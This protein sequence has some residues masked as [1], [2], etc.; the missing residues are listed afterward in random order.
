MSAVSIRLTPS[1]RARRSTRGAWSG[2]STIRIAPKPSRRT[3]SSPPSRNVELTPRSL[4][5]IL[6]QPPRHVQRSLRGCEPTGR[7]RDP[8]VDRPE[9]QRRP[10]LAVRVEDR[11]RNDP[12]LA[13][14]EPPDSDGGIRPRGED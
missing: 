7:D 12:P 8:V 13:T 3:S 10:K 11:M 9:W 14:D 4:T 1:S 6:E 2:S 5:Q